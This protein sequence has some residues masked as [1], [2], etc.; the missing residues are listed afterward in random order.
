M[1]RSQAIVASL[2][3][4]LQ[5]KLQPD[6]LIVVDDG[7]TDNTADVVRSWKDNSSPTFNMQL[8]EHVHNKGAAEARNS[9]LQQAANRYAY[10]Y[11]LDSDDI[12]PPNFLEKTVPTLAS[13]PDAVA[14]SSDRIIKHISDGKTIKYR[15]KKISKNPW[16][17][18]LTMGAGIAS[19]T[20]FRSEVI[21]KLGGY[22][23]TLPTGH[24][25]ELFMRIAD[26]GK[27]LHIGDCP[28]TFHRLESRLS[29]RYH[30]RYIMWCLI[31]ENSTLI[32][33][34]LKHI[35]LKEYRRILAHRWRRAGLIMHE[36]GYHRE[37]E[38]CLRRSLA[39][40]LSNKAII[41][42]LWFYHKQSL[43][44]FL[45]KLRLARH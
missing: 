41:D 14:V 33:T 27:W 25:V 37:A 10:I 22:N 8:I 24:D 2:N 12:P 39:W 30:H 36:N 43:R 5:Q 19:C 23:E 11:F 18:F 17:W 1:N 4:V 13:N 26:S 6:C 15:Q 20:V 34:A 9:A 21:Y 28:V 38:D 40:S 3:A 7:S 31:F 42:L 29:D 45:R 44:F 35:P 16:L 32:S